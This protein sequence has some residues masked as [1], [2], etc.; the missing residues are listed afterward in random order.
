MILIFDSA[1]NHRLVLCY[2]KLPAVLVLVL[3]VLVL[4][5]A[6]F[7]NISTRAR[8]RTR[9]GSEVHPPITHPFALGLPVPVPD[10]G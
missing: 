4:V 10:H 1:D 6:R 8:T 5:P 9:T 3:V 7:L 2:A